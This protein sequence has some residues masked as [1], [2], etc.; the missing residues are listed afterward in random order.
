VPSGIG[1]FD[2]RCSYLR[3]ENVFFN[4]EILAN[5]TEIFQ[6]AAECR[7]IDSLGHPVAIHKFAGRKQINTAEDEC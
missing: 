4:F 3:V 5:L 6:N 2:L 1:C 7:A